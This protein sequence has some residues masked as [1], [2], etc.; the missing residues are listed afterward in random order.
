MHDS[1]PNPNS[2]WFE[3]GHQEIIDYLQK[4]GSQEQVKRSLTLTDID[5]V[6]VTE[7]LIDLLIAK[8][9]FTFTELPKAVQDKL[10][11]R[12]QLRKDI[13]SL[14]NLINSDEDIF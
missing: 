2:Q 5:M 10:G 14:S 4:T 9:V 1:P 13:S 11:A 8:Q 6:R 12:K 7:D 3:L